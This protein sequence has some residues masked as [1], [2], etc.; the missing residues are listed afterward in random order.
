MTSI[1]PH[2]GQWFVVGALDEGVS[3]EPLKAAK[4]PVKLNFRGLQSVNSIGLSRLIQFVGNF[5]YLGIEYHEVPS[6]LIRMLNAVPSLLGPKGDPR[7]VKSLN[8]PFCCASCNTEAEPLVEMGQ[9]QLAGRSVYTSPV[10]CPRC[11]LLMQ[12]NEDPT[13]YFLFLFGKR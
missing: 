6:V 11:G 9:I 5:G 4:P 7:I 12:L 3:F 8:V 13:D 10:P 1:T 2:E